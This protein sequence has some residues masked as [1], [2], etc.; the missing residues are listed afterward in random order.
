MSKRSPQKTARRRNRK[1]RKRKTSDHLRLV[2]QKRECGE[3]NLCCKTI[4]T[5]QIDQN[6]VEF[7]KPEWEWCPNA[8][9]TGGGC[10]IYADR[11]Q[12][13]AK[14]E[15]MWLM[16][17]GTEEMRP[18]KLEAIPVARDVDG[19]LTLEFYEEKAGAM[20]TDLGIDATAAAIEELPGLEK[21]CI[22]H[23]TTKTLAF[24]AD[25]RNG[26]SDTTW[27]E[28]AK[29][30]GVESI[31]HDWR[32]ESWPGTINPMFRKW[33]KDGKQFRKNGSTNAAHKKEVHEMNDP[34]LVN[35]LDKEYLEEYFEC[36]T[37]DVTDK[38]WECVYPLLISE[39]LNKLIGG[40]GH[41][42]DLFFM[43][44]HS[45]T[46]I[47]AD[48]TVYFRLVL[49]EG[50]CTVA[51]TQCGAP[52]TAS[53]ENAC[54]LFSLPEEAYGYD[55]HISSPDSYPG[56]QELVASRSAA[57]GDTSAIGDA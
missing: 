1:E 10:E 15:C 14:W 30:Q 12:S 36:K 19:V 32:V 46:R 47:Q 42:W 18:D 27:E 23:R 43:S 48:Y 8:S 5:R 11:P 40:D 54:F 26:E 56:L 35:K 34:I 25:G 57:A 37:V 21:I 31:T 17:F 49:K 3:C 9:R 44:G 50:E 45:S 24:N 7:I 41:Y 4:A 2:D 51:V 6:G 38:V 39:N 33:I 13:C 29:A 52:R 22:F 55:V 16:G 20:Q 53:L 28:S